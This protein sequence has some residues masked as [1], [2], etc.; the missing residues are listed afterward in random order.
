MRRREVILANQPQNEGSPAEKDSGYGNSSE[1]RIVPA[2]PDYEDWYPDQDE[3][4]AEEARYWR[5]QN[6]LATFN[7]VVSA[8]TLAAAV[9]AA[10][11]AF[12]AFKETKRQADAAETQIGIAR[13][14]E[15]RQLRPYLYVGHGALVSYGPRKFGAEIQLHHSGQM[16]AY[17]V[18]MHATV[19]VAQYRL[20]DPNLGDIT[21]MSDIDHH[22]YSAL[23][24][25]E[26]A[27]ETVSTTFEPQ[28]IEMV[29][30]TDPSHGPEQ[31]FY[32]FG[33]VRYLD[34]F[35]TDEHAYR[36]CFVFHPER[37]RNG[38]EIGCEKYNKPG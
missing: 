37:D 3:Y 33:L 4:E 7:I 31:R 36:F 12:Y 9:A 28:V 21:K 6:W 29:M 17:K 19:T 23:Q 8:L 32:L 10:Y 24:G 22:E 14:T 5:R 18:R 13:E 27:R 20:A 25:S 16:P 30:R 34:I 1:P 38:S 35:G 2:Y 15:V 26:P 11:V